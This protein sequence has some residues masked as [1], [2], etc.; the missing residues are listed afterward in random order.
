MTGLLAFAAVLVAAMSVPTALYFRG[1]PPAAEVRFTIETPPANNPTFFAVSP[2]GRSVVVQART[3]EGPTLFRRRLDSTGLERLPG[4]EGGGAP[5]WSPDGRSIAFF[6]NSRLRKIDAAGGAA[7]DVVEDA[8]G[9]ASW[10]SGN[11][12]LFRRKGTLHA[13]DAAGGEAKPVEVSTG[14]TANFPTFL[15]DGN[16]FLYTSMEPTPGIYVAALHSPDA[17][18]LVSASSSAVYADPGLLLFHRQGT[19]F[20]QA[21]DPGTREIS[22]DPTQIVEQVYVNPNGRMAV[23]ASQNGVLIYRGGVTILPSQLA[24][25]DRTGRSLELL[26]TPDLYHP[27]F[28]L[29]P[30]ATQVALSIFDPRTAASKLWVMDW[31]RGVTTPFTF[32][33]TGTDAVWSPDGL[34]LAYTRLRT[35]TSGADIVERNASGLG[36]ERVLLDSPDNDF[37][38]DWSR[39]GQYLAFVKSARQNDIWVLPLSGERSPFPVV[40]SPFRKDEPHF[41]FDTKWLAYASTES[42]T[43]QIYVVSFPAM[44]QKRQISNAGGSQP[45]WNRDGTELYYLSVD[46]RMMAVTINPGA[47]LDSGVPRVLFETGLTSEPTLDQYAVTPDGQR[48]LLWKPTGG[49][50]QTPLSV[51]VNWTTR[52]QQ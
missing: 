16:H 34:K 1:A 18:L 15:P 41:S 17:H 20:A 22:G 32:E 51:V 4:T 25:Y 29:S 42:G 45:R 30:D 5:F 23:G 47:R 13:V 7:Q 49:E 36:E 50:A 46:G 3:E 38:E 6:A 33:R 19:V 40:E 43:W 12:I 35:G 8:E 37:V 26:G 39:D 21:F 27:N 31:A 11:V 10:G 28:D 48:F 14:P 2:D 24:W 44:D 9:P 52:L